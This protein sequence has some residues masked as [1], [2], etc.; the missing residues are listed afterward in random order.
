MIKIFKQHLFLISAVTSW[1][2][3]LSVLG[4]IEYIIHN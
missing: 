2:V 3:L 1:A 4:V